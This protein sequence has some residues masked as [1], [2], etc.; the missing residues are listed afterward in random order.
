MFVPHGIPAHSRRPAGKSAH[1]RRMAAAGAG[2]SAAITALLGAMLGGIHG[3][4]AAAGAIVV[5]LA[6]GLGFVVARAI[7]REL[8]P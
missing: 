1:D 5:L 2:I 8:K 4:S 6:A 3:G 7:G